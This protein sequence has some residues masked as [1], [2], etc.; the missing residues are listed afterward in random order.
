[1]AARAARCSAERAGGGEEEGGEGR[2][3]AEGGGGGLGSRSCCCFCFCPSCS[4]S[5]NPASSRSIATICVAARWSGTWFSRSRSSAR[6]KTPP[7]SFRL[8]VMV[9]AR[10]VVPPSLLVS[11]LSSTTMAPPAAS[12]TGRR[13]MRAEKAPR[14]DRKRR[15]A[16]SGTHLDGETRDD[17][18]F[19]L[20][21][22]EKVGRQK[23]TLFFLFPSHLL[24]PEMPPTNASQGH[25]TETVNA[26]RT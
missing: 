23:K 12:L 7:S 4:S 19:F 16:D 1:M 26:S 22:H 25:A 18:F 8:S 14:R 21:K 5:T 17:F 9:G 10:I 11:G 20:K 24:V 15:R 2:E 6:L 13:C 3:G